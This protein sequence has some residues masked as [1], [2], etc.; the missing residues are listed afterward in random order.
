MIGQL[1][2]YTL[3]IAT[4]PNIIYTVCKSGLVIGRLLNLLVPDTLDER[5][6]NG[7]TVDDDENDDDDATTSTSELTIEELLKI[8]I[9]SEK[10]TENHQLCMNSL[11]SLGISVNKDDIN[12][13]HMSLGDPHCLNEFFYL[14]LKYYV[15]SKT[16]DP[17]K[18][19]NVFVD[20]P[21][22][23]LEHRI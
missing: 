4:T 8:Q 3:D 5:A 12:V 7:I 6:L 16:L 14:L 21:S 20:V 11:N 17:S 19:K 18:N 22:L 23:Y 10:A 2:D 13:E 9:T 15:Q 1:L